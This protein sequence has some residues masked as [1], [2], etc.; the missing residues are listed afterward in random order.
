MGEP[1]MASLEKHIAESGNDYRHQKDPGRFG[2]SAERVSVALFSGF[3][4]HRRQRQRQHQ[5]SS[6]GRE[7]AVLIGLPFQSERVSYRHRGLFSVNPSPFAFA[8]PAN[9]PLDAQPACALSKRR[10]GRKSSPQYRDDTGLSVCGHCG[11]C[12]HVA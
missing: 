6:S 8:S 11:L 2:F 12:P 9:Q 4:S 5:S 3:R 7:L 1:P 10:C